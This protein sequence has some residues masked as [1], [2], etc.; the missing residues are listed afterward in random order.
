M[1]QAGR[2]VEALPGAGAVGVHPAAQ[3]GMAGQQPI[4]GALQGRDIQLARQ[5]QQQRD[6]VVD[7]VGFVQVTGL[8]GIDEPD[9]FLV[10]GQRQARGDRCQWADLGQGQGRIEF[11][12][13]DTG[14]RSLSETTQQALEACRQ[15]FDGAGVEQRGG[16]RQAAGQAG[17][18]F[19]DMQRQVVL[20]VV[21]TRRQE[22]QAQPR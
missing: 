15:A 21:F 2:A 14:L 20:G 13:A 8:E 5:L 7:R 6:V 4:E 22:L 19:V 18:A 17:A 16:I 3:N 10:V 9:P 1:Y 12:R 11:Q